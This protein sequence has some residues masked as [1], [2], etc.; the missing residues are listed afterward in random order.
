MRTSFD[1][2]RDVCRALSLVATKPISFTDLDKICEICYTLENYS[3]S[4]FDYYS[5]QKNR[6]IKEYFPYINWK[7]F[8]SEA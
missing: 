2:F 8:P 4:S 5:E 6:L 7:V 3:Y 1:V